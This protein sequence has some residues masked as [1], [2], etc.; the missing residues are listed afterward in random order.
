M[1]IRTFGLARS[2]ALALLLAG[3]ATPASWAWGREG[4]RL[5][6]LVAEHYLTPETR[7]AVQELL[8]KESMAGVASWADEFR[9][10]HPETGKW[11]FADIPNSESVYSRERDCPASPDASSAWRDCVVDR[12]LYFE[13]RLADKTLP[14]Q[15][16]YEALKYLIH[17]IGDIHQPFHTMGDARGGNDISV[18][19][20]GSNMCGTY[21][22]NLHG[23][24][25]SELIDHHN[26]NEEKYTAFLLADIQEHDWE[27]RAGGTPVQWANVSH[28]YGVSAF[29][30]NGA[31]LTKEYYTEEIQ[32][33]D[34]ELALGGLRLARVLNTILG[35]QAVPPAAAS[36]NANPA[37]TPLPKTAAPPMQ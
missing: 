35:G 3:C 6:A 28:H 20:M 16:R 2:A 29:A 37:R 36:P 23:V 8:G 12:I 7:A 22:C 13:M 10:E 11:H 4:H 1:K 15:Q 17:F 31:L 21:K 18:T 5:T 9:T 26:L 34:A 25:D 30:P 14:R 24:W 27:K 19:F 32:V 33:V